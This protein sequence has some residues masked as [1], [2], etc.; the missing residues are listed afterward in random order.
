MLSREFMEE[1]QVFTSSI[2]EGNEFQG[3]KICFWS[4]SVSVHLRVSNGQMVQR[5]VDHVCKCWPAIEA[6][7]SSIYT[8]P[9]ECIGSSSTASYQ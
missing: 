3:L 1:D 6:S 5:H 8:H 7:L 9:V 4:G 2:P